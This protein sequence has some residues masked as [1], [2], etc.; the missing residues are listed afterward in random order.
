VVKAAASPILNLIRRT[1]EDQRVREL[2]DSELLQRFHAQQDQAAFYAMLRRHGAMVL[3]VCRGILGN[4]ADAEDAFQATFL[5]LARKAG[6]IRKAASLA[7]WLHGVAY[8]TALKARVQSA[9]RRKHQACVPVR[10]PSVPD[11]LSWREVRQVLHEELSG[12]PERYR[13]PLV[14]CYLEGATQEA[15]AALLS[16]AKSTL[17]GRLERGREL[18]RRR[19]LGRGVGLSALLVA[20][21]WPTV[22][23]SASISIALLVSTVKAATRITAGSASASF[24]SAKVTAIT[25]GVLNAMFLSKLKTAAAV[26]L[27]LGFVTA[28][29]GLSVYIALGAERPA[30]SQGTQ[31]KGQT[32]IATAQGV[33]Q[34]EKQQQ[35]Q[36]ASKWKIGPTLQGHGGQVSCIAFSPDGKRLASGSRDKCVVLWDIAKRDSLQTL[37]CAG[38]VLA[39]AF[40]PDGKTLVTASGMDNDENLIKFWD[41]ETGKEQA[42][43]KGQTNPIHSL[44]FSRDGKIL[45]SASCPINVGAAA[46]DNRGEVCFWDAGAKK[47]IATLKGELVFDAALSHDHKKLVTSGSGRDGTVKLWDID[48]KFATAGETV[49]VQNECCS[50]ALSPDGKTFVTAPVGGNSSVASLWDFETGKVL[51]TFEHPKASVRNV[52]FTP[53]GKTL[54]TGCWPITKT[55]DSGEVGGEVK[56]WDVAT[57]EEKQ[58]LAEKLAPVTSLAFSPDGQTLAVGLLH[59]E[60]VK[61]KE[62]GGFEPPP[63][64]QSG[65]VVLCELQKR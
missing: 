32:N 45:V 20:A 26:L 6:S 28:G 54:A 52:A 34:T 65:V 8:R 21:A 18:L 49:L 56:T 4:E 13:A 63:E 60:K 22:Y 64:S 53:D 47:K 35:V 57:G 33:A 11:D 44:S 38:E 31:P 29:G 14:L 25:E 2:P 51:N 30:T 9:A 16:V 3:D 40:A 10:Q 7:S 5:I 15:A 55:G 39:V 19:L 41:P 24:V 12:L 62:G 17:R 59:K 50:L 43:L 36:A 58:T 27:T 46:V 42:V 1:V 23:A 37:S 61:L 48:E